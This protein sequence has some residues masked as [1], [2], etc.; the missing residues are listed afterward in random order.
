MLNNRL[1]PPLFC[2][3]FLLAGCATTAK[4]QTIL[5]NWQGA[6]VQDLM[7]RWG[8]PQAVMKQPNGH[9]TYLYT[10]Q[11]IA[12]VPSPGAPQTNLTYVGNTPIL[13]NGF[14]PF[15]G[16]TVTLYCHTLF[17]ANAQ[18]LILNARFQGNDCVSSRS[19]GLIP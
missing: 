16:N 9:T 3:F 11:H 19:G 1:L 10:R 8:N 4:Y 14:T 13:G 2:A 17:E 18:G 15:S 6:R 5:N 7:N 12:T